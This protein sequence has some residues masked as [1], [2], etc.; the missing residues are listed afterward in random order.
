MNLL[1][2]TQIRNILSFGLVQFCLQSENIVNTNFEDN[3]NV[4]NISFTYE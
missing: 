1:N 2:Q 4:I 3:Y